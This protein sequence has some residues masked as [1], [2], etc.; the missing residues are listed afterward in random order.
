MIRH[1]T[2]KNARITQAIELRL[3]VLCS[4]DYTI[5]LY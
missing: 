1:V 5:G 4:S 3:I 2:R